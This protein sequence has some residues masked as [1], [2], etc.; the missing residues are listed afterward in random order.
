MTTE[1]LTKKVIELDERTV[2]HS[3]QIKNCETKI[4]DIS[5]LTESVNK[6]ATSVQVLANAQKSTEEKV[7]DLSQDIEEI[8]EKPAK[9]WEN[10]V[11][12]VFELVLTAVVTFV[13]IKMGL[14]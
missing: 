3:E 11:H 12:L 13:L 5:K 1:D 10:T 2:R 4:A 6:M 14:K 9:R 8:K 7:D